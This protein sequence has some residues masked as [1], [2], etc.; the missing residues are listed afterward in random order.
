MKPRGAFAMNSRLRLQVG[1]FLLAVGVLMLGTRIEAHHSFGAE[2]DGE[3]PITLKGAITKIEW[4]NPHCHI[5]LDVREANGTVKPW[6]FEG[7]PPNV[8][9]RTGFKK[10]VTLKVGDTITVFAW[11]ARNGTALAH[12]REITFADGKKLYFGPPAGTGE[13]N[14]VLP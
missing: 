3:K 11:L 14:A 10:D 12:A 2:Y 13:G 5:Y 8:L 1:A 9:A 4:A 6:K 7:Y